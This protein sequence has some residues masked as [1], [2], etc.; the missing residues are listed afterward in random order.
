ML[1]LQLRIDDLLMKQPF[2]IHGYVF[3]AMPSVVVALSDGHHLGRGEAAGVYYLRDDPTNMVDMIES[4]RA[5]IE[6]GVTRDGLR[7]LL[8]PGGARNALDCALWELEAARAGQPVWRLAGLETMKPLVTTLTA[9]AGEP[10]AMAQTAAS[11]AGAKAIKLKLTGDVDLDVRRVEAVRDACPN[12]WLAVD[13]NQGYTIDSLAE[14]LPRFARSDVKLVEQP[15]ARGREAELDGF[16]SAIPLAADES[17]LST[18]DLAGLVGRFQIVNIKLDKCGGLTEALTM[19]EGARALGLGVMVGNMAGTSWAMAPAF[20]VGQFCEVV[21]LD[22]PISLKSDRSPAVDYR[23][24]EI[25]CDDA[26]WGR[27]MAADAPVPAY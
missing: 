3:D 17:A 2:A 18:A 7:R 27:G 5:E 25:W 16:S 19:V 24:G 20:I 8:P 6:A 14:V 26:V 10:E 21:D 23:D 4:V 15:L 12:V 11:F 9:G 13:A 22:G 1:K